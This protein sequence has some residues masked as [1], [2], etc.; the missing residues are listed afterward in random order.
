MTYD[1]SNDTPYGLHASR[2]HLCVNNAI[3][4]FE[5]TIFAARSLRRLKMF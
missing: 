5:K 1:D 3:L 4:N 2:D